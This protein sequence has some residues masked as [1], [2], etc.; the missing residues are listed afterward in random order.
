MLP[1]D[2]GHG[3][4]ARR[5]AVRFVRSMVPEEW[6][7]GT[8]VTRLGVP[9]S[10]YCRSCA[11][12][13]HEEHNKGAS[14]CYCRYCSDDEGHLKP[15]QEVEQIL[16]GWLKRGQGDLTSDEA[17]RRAKLFMQAMPAWCNN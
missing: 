13:L 8:D 1:S 9:A 6:T 5:L 2:A 11:A 3:E 12:P 7:A 17:A 14:D 15:R 10:P 16:A 4:I